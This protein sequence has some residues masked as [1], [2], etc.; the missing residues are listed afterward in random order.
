MEETKIS[1]NKIVKIIEEYNLSERVQI[2]ENPQQKYANYFK[3]LRILNH[4]Q[5]AITEYQKMSK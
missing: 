2:K 5:T 1:N 4:E 3:F